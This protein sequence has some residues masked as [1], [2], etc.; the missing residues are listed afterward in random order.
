MRYVVYIL[1]EI[2]R[3]GTREE[4]GRRNERDNYDNKVVITY[5]PY[6]PRPPHATPSITKH[7]TSL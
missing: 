2:R 3:R 1:K 6:M 7:K 5:K 4:R